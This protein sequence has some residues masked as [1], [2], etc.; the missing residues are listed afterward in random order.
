MEHQILYITLLFHNDTYP[1]P[2][3]VYYLYI[4]SR[5]VY[6]HIINNIYCR[7]NQV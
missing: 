2:P 4:W 7:L 3:S 6:D 5:T 1:K